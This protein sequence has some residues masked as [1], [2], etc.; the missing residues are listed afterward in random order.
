MDLI[1]TDAKRI[2]Q[3]ILGAYNFDLSFGSDENNFEL[4]LGANEP[5]LAFGDFVYI[6]GTEYG[7][8]IDARKTGTDTE[9]ITYMGRTFHGILQ[10]KIIEPD[11]GQDYYTVSG[12]AN[13]AIS[14]LI[15]RFGISELL[16]VE[17]CS[18]VSIAPYR[19]E[20]YCKGYDGIRDMLSDNGA[21]LQIRWNNRKIV[22]SAVP[23]TDYTQSP[24]DSDMAALTVEQHAKKVNHLICLGSG[25]LSSRE[26]LH[27]YADQFGNISDTQ[28]YT[29]IDEIAEIYDFSAVATSEELRSYGEKR[30][31]ELHDNDTAE[32]SF[33]NNSVSFDIGDIVGAEEI[34]SG[35][36]V[37]VPVTQKIVTVINGIVTID[38]KTGKGEKTWQII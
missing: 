6:E 36:T 38:Y 31:K 33:D 8:I 15:E 35:V 23:V 32:I 14:A 9:T 20:R 22:L 24:I 4:T 21:K 13:E 11:A 19:F 1:Y 30:M 28:Y 34:K 10:S 5:A 17:S 26:V 2:D 7:G 18:S 37:A 29:G 12:D 16:S 3:G 25:E 27:L